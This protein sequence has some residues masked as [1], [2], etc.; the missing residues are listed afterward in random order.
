MLR[1]RITSYNVCYTKLLRI[2]LSYEAMNAEAAKAPIGSDGLLFF[3]FG[4]GA[5]R[6]LESSNEGAQLVGL[7]FNVHSRAHVLRARN[8]FV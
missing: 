1:F 6:I 7:N 5:E 4:N 8:N 3:P 2:D